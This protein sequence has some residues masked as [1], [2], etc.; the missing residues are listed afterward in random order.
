[1][2]TIVAGL[3]LGFAYW[4]CGRW[5]YRRTHRVLNVGLLL[6]GV[7]GTLAAAWLAGAFLAGRA[8]LLAAQSQ[9]STPVQALAS[10]DIAVLKA[11]S[12]EALTLI[13][14]SGNDQNEAGFQAQRK[15]LG[16]GPGTLLTIAQQ[17]AAG[18]PGAAR[19]AAASRPRPRGSRSTRS[20]A[21]TTTATTPARQAGA[22]I[23]RR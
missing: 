7:A 2:V 18:S 10:A 23:R 12:D 8:D 21:P 11:H 20:S 17:A 16:P 15:A 9:G 1:M 4:R 22:P 6:A 5:I 3:A 14:N 13:N 19:A